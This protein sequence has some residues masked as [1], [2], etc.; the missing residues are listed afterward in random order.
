MH[1]SGGPKVIKKQACEHKVGTSRLDKWKKHHSCPHP[2]QHHC[3][4][5][6][7]W[8][9]PLTPAPPGELFSWVVLRSSQ[10]WMW[11]GNSWI[12]K[13]WEKRGKA[14]NYDFNVSLQVSPTYLSRLNYLANM[15]WYKSL[16]RGP[17]R[18]KLMVLWFCGTVC[19]P[20]SWNHFCGFPKLWKC[21]LLWFSFWH[22][23]RCIVRGL[24]DGSVG[25][26]VSLPL[27]SRLKCLNNCE[28][29]CTVILYLHGPTEAES[30]SLW[31]FSDLF[32]WHNQKVKVFTY[33]VNTST[34]TGFIGPN[35]AQ[36]F[37]VSAA[38]KKTFSH[39]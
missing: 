25:Q 30:N 19:V 29:D 35:S 6:E 26:S 17:L 14:L 27:C 8:T 1:C 39:L 15:D 24:M 20:F 3:G 33:S 2:L 21:A 7:P 22:E 11:S 5:L 9:R 10:V 23:H 12:N 18:M 13:G 16:C 32:P 36:I 34:F 37:G 28:W 31:W 38:D 4:G